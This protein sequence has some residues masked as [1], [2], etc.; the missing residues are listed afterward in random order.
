MVSVHLF[1]PLMISGD[2]RA[3]THPAVEVGPGLGGALLVPAERG[4]TSSA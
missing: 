4:T 2:Y 3:E 1:F